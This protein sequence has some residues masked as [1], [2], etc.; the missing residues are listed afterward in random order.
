MATINT[1]SPTQGTGGQLMTLTGTGFGPLSSSVK[2]NFGTKSVTGTVTVSGTTATCTIPDA[3]AG[4][5]T[6][7]MTVGSTISNSKPF[8]YV[9]AP[10]CSSLSS[11][12]GPA[13]P[14][15]PITISGSGLASATSVTFG[16]AAPILAANFTK[17]GDSL[18]TN[19]TPPNHPGAIVGDTDTVDVLITGPGGTSIPSGGPTQFVYYALPTVTDASPNTG[20]SS[21]PG[22]VINGTHLVDVSDVFFT[23]PAA[24]DFPATDITSLSD[25]QVVVTAPAGLT[26]AVVY[27]VTVRT[28]GGDGVA[29]GAFTAA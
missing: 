13:A 24:N 21:E 2:V 11:N 1:I 20:S 19:I 18:I 8:F 6:V 7:S 10:Q 26:T 22:I 9:D 15:V 27:D 25:L 12:V 16:V 14:T 4:Q 5:V 3:C 17:V 28:P 29:L 23:D